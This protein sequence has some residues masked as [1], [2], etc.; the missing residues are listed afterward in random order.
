MPGIRVTP[1]AVSMLLTRYAFAS[2]F[3]EDK[4]VLELACGAGMGLGY[5]ARHS[6]RIVGGDYTES[7]L[8]VAKRDSL[9][10]VPLIR[11]DAQRL[12]FQENSFDVVMLFE[13]IY[14]LPNPGAFLQECRRILRETGTLLVCSANKECPGFGA[15]DLSRGYF[16]ARELKELLE[17]NGFESDVYGGFPTAAKNTAEK[18]K[19]SIRGLAVRLN[20]IPKTM[21]GKELLKRIFYGGLVELGK[22]IEEHTAPYAAPVLLQPEMQG[23]SNYKVIYVVGRLGCK[24]PM[25]KL[26]V[27]TEERDRAEC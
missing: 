27:F 10:G 9:R 18:V 15:S 8:E 3:C 12:P 2:G 24:T 26:A 7:M 4:D 17:E 14:Y 22:S 19:A 6:R 23:A 21:R 25:Q 20:L 11:L 1:E 13:A 16:S 5:L